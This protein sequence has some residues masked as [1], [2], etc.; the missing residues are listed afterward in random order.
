MLLK[1]SIAALR[2]A[3]ESTAWEWGEDMIIKPEGRRYFFTL[4]DI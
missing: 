1:M 3:F 2:K 4:D